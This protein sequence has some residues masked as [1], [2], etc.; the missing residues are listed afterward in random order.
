MV[1]T[2]KPRADLHVHYSDQRRDDLLEEAQANQ[3]E[4]VGL[5]ERETIRTNILQHVINEGVTRGLRLVPGIEL[6][7]RHESQGTQS[8]ELI[9]LDFNL[10]NPRIFNEL[11]PKGEVYSSVHRR[12]VDFQ[13]EFLANLG[14]NMEPIPETDAA[15]H[16][17][18]SGEFADTAIRLSR[19]AIQNPS[20]KSVV[21]HLLSSLES[22][23]SEY[24]KKRPEDNGDSAKFLYWQHFA[25]GKPGQKRWTKEVQPKDLIQL[26][27]QAGGLVIL[28]HPEEFN[29]PFISYML[30]EVGV[31]GLE[32]WH[33]GPL[34]LRL[35]RKA[36]E[37]GKLVLGGSGKSIEDYNNRLIGL[38][39]IETQNMF[40]PAAKIIDQ[41][42]EYKRN[43]RIIFSP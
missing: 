39:D 41:I 33:A 7:F 21:D 30:D 25:L 10:Q 2:E 29:D 16:N 27:H 38:G 4:V 28:A 11:D 14:F 20:N 22:E 6:L 12:K 24:L 26:I 15:W 9:C 18:N 34:N 35:A 1:I 23:Y 31:D 3:T 13:T 42:E 8:Y 37:R 40:I 17:L 5:L 36:L 32:G 43:A 19:I